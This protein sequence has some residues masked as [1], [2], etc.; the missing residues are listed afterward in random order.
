[1]ESP[2]EVYKNNADRLGNVCLDWWAFFMEENVM[3]KLSLRYG[4]N[5]DQTPANLIFAGSQASPLNVLNGQP[6][7]VNMLDA[8]NSWQL[9]RELQ[10]ATGLASAASF[11]HVSP[12]GVGTAVYIDHALCQ[13]YHISAC[14][15]SPIAIAYVRARGADRMSSYGDFIALSETCDDETAQLIQHEVSD[16][17]IA[18]AYTPEALCILSKKKQ[19]KY[20]ILQMDPAYQ[21]AMQNETRQ[22]FGFELNQPHPQQ[23][24]SPAMLRNIPTQI[25]E[26]PDDAVRDLIIALITTK[27]T[28]SNSVCYTLDGRTIGVGAGQQSRVHCVRLAGDKADR[29]FLRQHPAILD[30]PFQTAMTRVSTDNVIDQILE[31][32]SSLLLDEHTWPKYFTRKPVELEAFDHTDWL[33]HLH[34]VSLA[35]D[36]FFPFSDNIDRAVRSGVRFIAQPG[37]SLRDE[38]VI[39]ACNRY[40]ITMAMTGLRLFWH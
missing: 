20:L 18:P 37:G 29:W 22:V 33:K 39:A 26:L 34:N 36:G 4:I 23:A 13:S 24:I 12:A 17:V 38:K 7:Y 32:G 2:R 6:S 9:V 21:P 30:L 28:Q 31:V 25:T 1:M 5:P 14:P 8:L 40:Q 35:S 10:A 27:Y 11:K 15:S 16:G 19:G 3:Q